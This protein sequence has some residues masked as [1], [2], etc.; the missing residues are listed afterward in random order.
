MRVGSVVRL[1][2][3]G[4]IGIV[5]SESENYINVLF[6]NYKV[7]PIKFENIEKTGKYFDLSI[8]WG[9]VKDANRFK[10]YEH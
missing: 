7:Y 8:M 1:K 4:E 2:T 10:E 3:T 9:M 6:E 5:V